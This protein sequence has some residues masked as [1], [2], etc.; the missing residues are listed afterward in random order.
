MTA[1]AT[2]GSTT[3]CPQCTQPPWPLLILANDRL[4]GFLQRIHVQRHGLVDS[5]EVDE[6]WSRPRSGVKVWTWVPLVGVDVMRWLRRFLVVPVRCRCGVGVVGLVVRAGTGGGP[7][8]A[9][10][11]L[12][13]W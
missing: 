2:A 6:G 10:A 3:L 12:V 1:N 7:E 8:A 13:S 5:R 11:R 9:G 4:T